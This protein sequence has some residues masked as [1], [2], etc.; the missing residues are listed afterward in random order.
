MRAI[1]LN[2]HYMDGI[3]ELVV[4]KHYDLRYDY[5]NSRFIIT[6]LLDCDGDP[7]IL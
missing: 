4:G 3:Q 6:N 1:C 5:D 7:V 2:K